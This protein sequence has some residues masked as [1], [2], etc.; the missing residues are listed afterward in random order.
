M[1]SIPE[2]IRPGSLGVARANSIDID[3]L[4]ILAGTLA[5]WVDAAPE[6]P[7]VYL[8]GS[9]VR[10]DHRAD[11]DVNVRLHL[12]RWRNDPI[13]VT[14]RWW[15]R[16]ILTNFAGLKV[17]LPGPLH[18]HREREDEADPAIRVG[19]ARPVLVVRKT[20]CVWTPPKP[21]SDRA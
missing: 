9:R 12:G 3:D 2:L 21:A 10:G 17:R 1:N 6:I 14:G 20:I 13:G 19:E 8:F 15:L 4:R 18:L 7:A 5:D 16:Q 11:S